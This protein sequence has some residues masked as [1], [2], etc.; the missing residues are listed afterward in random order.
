MKKIYDHML[1]RKKKEGTRLDIRV[2]K[3]SKD[4]KEA[5]L[6]MDIEKEKADKKISI[7][8]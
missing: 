7:Y 2:N 3:F 4:L 6:Q 5:Q 1:Y 8:H